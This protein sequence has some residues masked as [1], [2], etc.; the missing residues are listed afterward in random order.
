MNCAR[1]KTGYSRETTIALWQ[2]I[3]LWLV[4]LFAIVCACQVVDSQL[5][6]LTCSPRVLL[7]C[8]ESNFEICS[9]YAGIYSENRTSCQNEPNTNSFSST[10][11]SVVQIEKNGLPSTLK[12]VLESIGNN[13]LT[14]DVK[15]DEIT[16]VIVSI[17]KPN[18]MQ[19]ASLF[20]SGLKKPLLGYVPESTLD[21]TYKVTSSVLLCFVIV[22]INFI[23][24]HYGYCN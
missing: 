5:L 4:M 9:R 10:N 21:E 18:A 20:A 23:G 22:F 7:M 19:I 14:D 15:L 2:L 16:D 13:T 12:T 1:K 11:V 6:A 17:G 3:S 8:D 24:Y